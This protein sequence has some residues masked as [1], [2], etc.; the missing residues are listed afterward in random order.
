MIQWPEL[1]FFSSVSFFTMKVFE[2][3]RSFICYFWVTIVVPEG[4]LS[5]LTNY[6][7]CMN[8]LVKKG[9]GKVSKEKLK[10][11]KSGSKPSKVA[12]GG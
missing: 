10:K 11:I 12:T 4:E 3:L 1:L 8:G 5:P 7:H 2:G 6:V 9:T